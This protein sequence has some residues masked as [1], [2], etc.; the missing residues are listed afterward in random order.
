MEMDAQEDQFQD[1]DMDRW[2]LHLV[3]ELENYNETV[4]HHNT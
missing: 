2:K 3:N 1:A 4:T